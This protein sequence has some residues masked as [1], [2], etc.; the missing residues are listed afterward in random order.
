MHEAR[1]DSARPIRVIA[2]ILVLAALYMAREVLIPAALA[3]LLAFLLQPLVMRLVRLGLNR[4]LA[5]GIVVILAGGLLTG[6]GVMVGKQ[7]LD[8]SNKLPQYSQNLREKVRSLRQSTGGPLAR[9][10]HTFKDIKEEIGTSQPATTPPE[11][12]EGIVAQRPVAVQVIDDGPDFLDLAKR[13][14]VPVLTPLTLLAIVALLLIFLLL[15]SEDVRDRLIWFAGMR[16]IS[17]TTAALDEAGRRISGY[18][19][20]QLIVN[21]SFGAM[22]AIGL[23]IVGLPSALLWGVMAAALRFIPFLGPWLAAFPPVLLAVAVFHGWG[24]PFGVIGVF[25]AV[26]LLTNMI[27]EPWL[28]GK[29]AGVSSLGIAVAMV[30]WAWLWGPVGLILAVPLTV[31]L[32]VFSRFIPQLALLNHLFGDNVEM[33]ASARLYQR[34]LAGDEVTVAKIIDEE[35]EAD[36]ATYSKVTQS[37]IM[38]VLQELKRDI[39]AGSIDMN[40]AKRSIAI[41]NSVT[42][43]DTKVEH[44]AEHPPMLCVAGQNEVDDFA[45]KLLSRV[46]GTEGV[47]AKAISSQSLAS[48]VAE[49]AREL[50]AN[51]ICLVQVAPVSLTHCRQMAKTLSVRVPDSQVYAINIEESDAD[52]S[53]AA[54]TCRLPANR[55]FKD[56]TALMDKLREVQQTPPKPEPAGAA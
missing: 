5:V 3:I 34:L 18:L 14:L 45:A 48:E 51:T 17:L 31:V 46:A 27:L 30:F 1:Y 7:F 50:H 6:I 28:Y 12:R 8:L 52:L 44:D 4:G 19:R 42:A 41:L 43:T 10:S 49:Q 53:F 38:P 20:M 35:L 13:F 54:G 9:L 11:A 2:G 56:V 32:L 55:M 22:I 40:L 21:L 29:S 47:A 36:E 26:E 39:A 24:Q 37:V 23:L 16:Q 15:H 25:V 33:P